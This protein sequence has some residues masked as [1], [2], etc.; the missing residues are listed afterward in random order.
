MIDLHIVPLEGELD[1]ALELLT[2][3]ERERARR[4]VFDVHRRRFAVARAGLRRVLAG[5]LGADPAALRFV[6]GAHGKP[7]LAGGELEFNLSHSHELAVV[8][9]TRLAPIGVDVEHLRHVDGALRIAE[10]H[11]APSERAALAAAPA[12]ERD[13]VF[14][15][16]WTRK[17]AFIKAIGEGLSH[18]LQRFELTL[19]D[20]PRFV[21][22]DGDV[23]AAARWSLFSF[24]PAPGYLAAV[25]APW[26]SAELRVHPTGEPCNVPD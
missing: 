21:T 6:E 5:H 20:A 7:A 8:G 13:L 2:P 22:I 18:P 14:M 19:D 25:A 23:A 16:G 9:V 3:D 17:E 4:F 15:R 11:F 10:T 26:P 24:E 12:A 1:A